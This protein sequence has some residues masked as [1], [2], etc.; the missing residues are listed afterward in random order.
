MNKWMNGHFPECY[1]FIPSQ[2]I[3]IKYG[4]ILKK[5]LYTHTHILMN[6]CS[7]LNL[8]L[9]STQQKAKKGFKIQIIF[10]RCFQT[11]GRGN[12]MCVPSTKKLATGLWETN[13]R[14][15]KPSMQDCLPWA[16]NGPRAVIN[17][18]WL[19]F[20][21]ESIFIPILQISSHMNKDLKYLAQDLTTPV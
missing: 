11:S 6:K 13:G 20:F 1:Y 21:K 8:L 10:S 18:I 19:N 14:R 3:L 4:I 5:K 7:L 9:L 2:D 17:I 16:E 12:K 15:G